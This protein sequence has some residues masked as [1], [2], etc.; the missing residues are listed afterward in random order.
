MKSR[1]L[2]SK[3][4]WAEY[5]G[6]IVYIWER[7][8]GNKTLYIGSSLHGI[9]RLLTQHPVINQNN[10]KDDDTITIIECY[11]KEQMLQT[12]REGIEALQPEFNSIQGRGNDEEKERAEQQRALVLEGKSPLSPSINKLLKGVRFRRQTKTEKLMNFLEGIKLEK[13]NE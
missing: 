12:E 1:K 13:K 5:S 7:D 6:P 8:N 3:E 10:M 9:R 11:S 2:T 4:F